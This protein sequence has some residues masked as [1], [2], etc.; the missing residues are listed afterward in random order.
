VANAARIA[1]ASASHRRVEPSTSVNKNVTTPEGAATA[2][3]DT[4]AESHN[5][6]APTTRIGGIR[7]RKPTPEA[8]IARAR[9][10]GH[11]LRVAVS[12]RQ[13]SRL[14][15]LIGQADA[16]KRFAKLDLTQRR[17]IVDTL[18]K[19]TVLPTGKRGAA[20]DADLIEV[21]WRG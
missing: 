16:A 3:A 7:I 10:R 12:A 5:R 14:S 9:H 1:S 18:V 8:L 20:F 11:R 15:G 19:V 17:T 6:P 13:S 4:P 2:A 21:D